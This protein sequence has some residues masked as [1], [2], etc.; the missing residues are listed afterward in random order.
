MVYLFNV[1]NRSP[2]SSKMS[3]HRPTVQNEVNIVIKSCH[4]YTFNWMPLSKW[5]IFCE[6]PISRENLCYVFDLLSKLI[7]WVSLRHFCKRKNCHLHHICCFLKRAPSVSPFSLFVCLINFV[8]SV[9]CKNT[10]PC[11]RC[12]CCTYWPAYHVS[13]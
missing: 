7:K 2:H 8:L 10:E 9:A 6:F 11:C 1:N 12:R 13:H 5:F 4:S 3:V